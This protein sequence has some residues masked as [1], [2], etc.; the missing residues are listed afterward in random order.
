[1]NPTNPV[2]TYSSAL[3]MVLVFGMMTLLDPNAQLPRSVDSLLSKKAFKFQDSQ[4][5]LDR[6]M[7]KVCIFQKISLI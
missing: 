7:E 1:M 3:R 6:V 5:L 4:V 2:S